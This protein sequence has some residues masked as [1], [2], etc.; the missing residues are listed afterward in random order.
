MF[1]SSFVFDKYYI[2]E[3]TFL[4]PL[5]KENLS[6][7]LSPLLGQFGIKVFDFLKQLENFTDIYLCTD[8]VIP[9]KVLL[10]HT[11][12]NQL[13]MGVPTYNSLLNAFSLNSNPILD[14]LTFYKIACLFSLHNYKIAMASD[15]RNRNSVF[16]KKTYKNARNYLTSYNLKEPLRSNRITLSVPT[17][18][19]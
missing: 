6:G 17:V 19:F 1:F 16:I 2:R 15:H 5:G 11:G 12:H 13:Y 9:V 3:L 14:Y 10:N 4:L 8:I 7:Y 18:L